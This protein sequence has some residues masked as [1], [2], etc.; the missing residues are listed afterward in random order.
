VADR[1]TYREPALPPAGI[2]YVLV[3]GTVVVRDGRL[4]EDVRPGRPLR[5]R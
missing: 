1:A 4:V 5:A 2:P 3:N